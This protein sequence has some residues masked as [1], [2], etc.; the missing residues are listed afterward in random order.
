[1]NPVAEDFRSF[2]AQRLRSEHAE[3]AG[4]WLSRLTAIVPVDVEDV[5]PTDHLLDH[6][7]ELIGEIGSYLAD[8]A[9]LEIAA[10]ATVISKARELGL[11]RYG[12]H[13]SAH[14]IMREYRLFEGVLSTFIKEELERLQLAVPPMDVVDVLAGVH[15]AVSVLQQSTLDAFIDKYSDAV[16]TQTRRL[17]AFNRM[18][19]H[20][21]RQPLG[22]L[23]FALRLLQAQDPAESEQHRRRLIE[24]LDR[25][26]QRSLE[27]TSQLTRLSGLSATGD[28]LQ[29]QHVDLETV[30]Q[31]SSRQLRDMAD[32]RGVTIRISE[33]LPEATLDVAAAE[34]VLVNLI[35][36]AIKYS[37]PRKAD[38]FVEIG[39]GAPSE[40]E[41]TIEVRDN[42][43]GIPAAH[44]RA[45]FDQYVRAHAAQDVEL[46]N[47]G[48]GLGLTI[49]Q[50]CLQTMGGR[51]EVESCEGAGT[52]FTIRIPRRRG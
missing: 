47:S 23:Q 35:S 31:E 21:L 13:A 5:F 16:N 30:A 39:P 38:R 22:T 7:P 49:V 52:T 48:L 12:Q 1:M 18:V 24:L 15:Q 6:I 28:N 8:P 10:N 43:L 19:S 17:E 11:L 2:I 36:N 44:T 4:R 51:I 27:L 41:W 34:L 9:R 37:D 33:A 25:N 46:R 20:E 40:T 29:V 3:L 42:G 50:D 14:Q 45:I 32:A 26:V